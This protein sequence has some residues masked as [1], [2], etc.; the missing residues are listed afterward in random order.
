M[1]KEETPRVHEYG[2]DAMVAATKPAAPDCTTPAAFV[3]VKV[4]DVAVVGSFTKYTPLFAVF[5]ASVMVTLWY[6]TKPCAPTVVIVTVGVANAM[7]AIV[8]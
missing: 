4:V 2:F 3:S 7:D 6:C 8:D 1:S 5:V